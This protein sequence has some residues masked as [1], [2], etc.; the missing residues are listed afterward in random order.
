LQEALVAAL[1]YQE[2]GQFAEADTLYRRI[3]D[4]APDHAPAFHLWGI[5]AARTGQPDKAADRISRAIAVAPGIADFYTNLARVF[6]TLN[7]LDKVA[8]HYANALTLRPEDADLR[9]Q[10]AGVLHDLGRLDEADV[11]YGTLLTSAP[12]HANIHLNRALL[13]E[14]QGQLS[15][16]RRGF[17]TTLVLEPAHP[18]ALLRLA[19]MEQGLGHSGAALA[20]HS[21]GMVAL[22]GAPDGLRDGGVFGTFSAL[23]AEAGELKRAAEA[24]RAAAAL[25]PNS[26]TLWNDAA[27]RLKALGQLSES[28][29]AYGR[30]LILLAGN[31]VLLNNRADSWLKLGMLD[32]AEVDARASVVADPGFAS[33]WNILG[34]V[35]MAQG[36]TEE[37][38]CAYEHAICADPAANAQ[39]RF[40]RS[41]GLL[42]LGRLAE[43]WDEYE[44]GWNVPA[45]RFPH[46]G[47]PQ[48]PWDGIAPADGALLVWGEQGLGD[49]VMFASLI[50][51]LATE[52]VRVVLDC[53]PRLAPLL[54]RALPAVTIVPRTEPLSDRLIAPDIVAQS[55]A[56]SLPRRMRRGLDDFAGHQT[57][58]LKADPDRVTA[59]RRRHADGRRLIGISWSS[60]NASLGRLRSIPLD[61]LA[62][63]LDRPDVKL[64]SLQY[65]DVAAQIAATRIP[66][67]ID[68]TIDVWSDIDGLAAMIC[69]MDLI[70]SVDNSTVHLAGG[71][72]CPTWALLPY[73]ADWRWMRFRSDTPWYPAVRLLRQEKPGD[74][75]GVLKRLRE[76]V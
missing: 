37:A 31:S 52:G 73:F 43:G 65:G 36:R 75:E 59:A 55:P 39:A 42:T 30:A 25:A 71:L 18:K 72:G 28:T 74:W 53:D 7:R 10:L 32:R 27:N 48:P 49:E 56:G 40:N 5:L 57:P 47:F 13:W 19:A 22:R 14:A 45:G 60:K 3:L 11:Q 2:A 34:S 16:A 20:A 76:A 51:Q 58:F 50:P 44:Q 41:I 29:V 8:H 61:R 46:P 62:G 54:A 23:L 38:L 63:A 67:A 9:F 12:Q 24:A 64:I 15:K 26:A 4:V 69:A 21:R 17:Q 6:A 66:V 1:D 35:L 33:G 70:V 68:P